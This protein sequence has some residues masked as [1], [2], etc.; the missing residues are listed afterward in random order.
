MDLVQDEE[1]ITLF[2]S[3]EDPAVADSVTAVRIVRD[4]TSNI[5]KGFAFVQFRSKPAARAALALEGSRVRK[6]PIRVTRVATNIKPA[7][8][9]QKAGGK[10]GKPEKRAAGEGSVILSLKSAVALCWM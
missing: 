1:L 7:A 9:V 10:A 6:R 3:L 2:N 8:P 4:G 5:G